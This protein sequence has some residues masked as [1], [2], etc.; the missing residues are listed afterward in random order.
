M[1]N[2]YTILLTPST[3]IYTLTTSLP[4]EYLYRSANATANN[5]I[6]GFTIPTAFIAVARFVQ[7][8]YSASTST[9]LRSRMCSFEGFQGSPS[10][11]HTH[12]RRTSVKRVTGALHR[13]PDSHQFL[14]QPFTGCL[15][16]PLA[17]TSTSG[18]IDTKFDAGCI[19]ARNDFVRTKHRV[20]GFCFHTS[21]PWQ[22]LQPLHPS[23]AVRFRVAFATW[24]K[25]RRQAFR[26]LCKEVRYACR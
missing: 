21:S 6:K 12:S 20:R 2:I 19:S 5:R 3:P 26:T 22:G 8:S 13:L 24:V 25:R 10:V 15:H 17:H 1:N 7:C 23:Y 16:K 18:S 14:M 9:S 11:T 4:A